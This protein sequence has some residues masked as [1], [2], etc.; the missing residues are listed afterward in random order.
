MA[1]DFESSLAGLSTT[2]SYNTSAI[3]P[4]DSD[5]ETSRGDLN[6]TRDDLERRQ[7]IHTVQLLKLEISQKNLLIDN[8][9]A[10]QASRIDE[11]ME[12]LADATHEKQLIQL[13]LD[14]AVQSHR[15]ESRRLQERTQREIAALKVKQSEL[16]GRRAE[17]VERSAE[18]RSRVFLLTEEQYE[19][20]SSKDQFGLSLVEQLQLHVYGLCAPLRIECLQL[21]DRVEQ[22]E[23]HMKEREREMNECCR[24]SE[25]SRH[26]LTS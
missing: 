25:A 24:V 21:R 8:L 16:E 3:T 17:A 14:N 4:S 23:T 5:L 2:L 20:L 13:K 11:M 22:T 19:E 10:E 15:A 12:Q 7:L 9:K 1:D 18:L 26:R 6:V